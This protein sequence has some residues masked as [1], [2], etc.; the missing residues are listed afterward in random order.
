MEQAEWFQLNL[1]NGIFFVLKMIFF[2]MFFGHFEFLELLCLIE[3]R[4]TVV[5]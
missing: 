5:N 1:L 2:N 4:K 3:T